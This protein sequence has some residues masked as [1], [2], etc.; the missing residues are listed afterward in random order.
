M[1]GSEFP[2]RCAQQRALPRLLREDHEANVLEIFIRLQFDLDVLRERLSL[3]QL[4]N[5]VELLDDRNMDPILVAIF[6]AEHLRL[7]AIQGNSQIEIGVVLVC[8][9][10]GS[11][12][13]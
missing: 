9:V 13:A 11:M 1:I 4:S 12:C 6:S 10:V 3:G 8:I 7:D 5:F 2:H